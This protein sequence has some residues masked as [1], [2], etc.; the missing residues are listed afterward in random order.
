MLVRFSCPCKCMYGEVWNG[1]YLH[2][3]YF[4][5]KIL[6]LVKYD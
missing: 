2:V 4:R 3:G 1:V 5:I 6:V